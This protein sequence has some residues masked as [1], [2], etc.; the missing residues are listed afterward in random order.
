MESNTREVVSYLKWYRWYGHEV[1][2]TLLTIVGEFVSCADL[3]EP[4]AASILRIKV[5][6]PF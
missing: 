3:P 6:D 4:Q 2:Q 5:S 1:A